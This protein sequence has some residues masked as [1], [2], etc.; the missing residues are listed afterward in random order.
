[1][2]F[3]VLGVRL[4][5]VNDLLNISNELRVNFVLYL[6]CLFP[7]FVLH[8][9]FRYR[10]DRD[11][12]TCIQL[13]ISAMVV[14]AMINTMWVSIGGMDDLRG[15]M[16]WPDKDGEES[17]VGPS[18][19]GGSVMS[20]V[21]SPRGLTAVTS[22]DLIRWKQHYH[23]VPSIMRNG[24]MSVVFGA[25]ANRFL[26]SESYDFLVA[27]ADYRAFAALGG[28]GPGLQHMLFLDIC[29]DFVVVNSEQEINISQEQRMD[30]LR[31]AVYRKFSPLSEAEKGDI[32]REAEREVSQM[33]QLNLLL[34]FHK[35]AA[36][37]ETCAAVDVEEHVWQ[38]EEEN[39]LITNDRNGPLGAAV[40]SAG[41]VGSN[42]DD[43]ESESDGDDGEGGGGG[44]GGGGRGGSAGDRWRKSSG[45][46]L[47]AHL[48][49]SSA[50]GPSR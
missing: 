6:V 37:A 2:I 8:L 19:H 4:R 3:G 24:R 1:M 29:K 21:G 23:D 42:G 12:P 20:E 16:G 47:L 27:V 26:C 44:G 50:V 45:R 17:T 32:F 43:S 38:L 28:T 9:Y 36:F 18:S 39:S 35:S 5:N 49:L 15:V 31:Y 30:V 41:A 48:G 46:A 22:S 7:Y 40:G 34:T 11:V 14:L 33:L 25:L 13:L 10:T